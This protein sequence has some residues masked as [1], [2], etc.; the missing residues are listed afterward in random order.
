MSKKRILL[1]LVAFVCLGAV[2]TPVFYVQQAPVLLVSPNGVS[3]PF[4]YGAATDAAR[5]TA[6]LAAQGAASSGDTIAVLSDATITAALGKDQVNWHFPHEVFINTTAE[7]VPVFS[8]GGTPMTFQVTGNGRFQTTDSEC[9]QFKSETSEGASAVFLECLS[10]ESG[11]GGNAA[12]DLGGNGNDPNTFEPF[13]AAE[14]D[15][16][17][18]DHCTSNGYDALLDGTYRGY[19]KTI[20]GGDNVCEGATLFLT[21]ETATSTAEGLNPGS[22]HFKCKRLVPGSNSRAVQGAG[23]AGLTVEANEIMGQVAN[24]GGPVRVIG[25]IIDSTGN[26]DTPAAYLESTSDELRLDGCVLRSHSGATVDIDAAEDG[27]VNVVGGIYAPKG[28]APDITVTYEDTPAPRERAIQAVVFSPQTTVVTSDPNSDP[29][30]QAYI[31]VPASLDGGVIT[32]VRVD[33]IAAGTTGVSTIT[34][35]RIRSGADAYVLSTQLTIDSGETS[36]ET[37]TTPPV[38]NTSNDDLATSDL[39]RLDTSG[40]S[41]T[42]P[43]GLIVTIEVTK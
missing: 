36:S 11:G 21:C 28:F 32:D 5:G 31:V 2:A 3:R 29:D 24:E 39:L 10:V 15:L 12:I 4:G 16:L 9:I 18:K 26:T 8:D 27:I 25:A 23:A 20:V 37:A 35:Q 42:P 17:I 6:V 22:G 19:I 33:V 38:I 14:L 43:T 41:T 34:L 30:G 1:I 40:V 13:P 7:D